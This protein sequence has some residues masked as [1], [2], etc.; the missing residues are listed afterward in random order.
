MYKS[1]YESSFNLFYFKLLEVPQVF[2]HGGT[3]LPAV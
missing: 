1:L 2:H 3:I